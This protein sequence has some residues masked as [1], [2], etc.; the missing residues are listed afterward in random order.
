MLDKIQ[1]PSE[2]SSAKH[3][4]LVTYSDPN[5]TMVTKRKE[6]QQKHVR[7]PAT[8]KRGN[9]VYRVEAENLARKHMKKQGYRVHEVSHV[10]I[11]D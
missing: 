5:H 9:S 2:R 8:D 4:V 11:V 3:R 6:K 1:P 10:G 7:V